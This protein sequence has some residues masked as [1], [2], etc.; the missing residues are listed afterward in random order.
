MSDR[1]AERPNHNM[2]TTNR[3]KY[4]ENFDN[5]QKN[6]EPPRETNIANKLAI[7]QLFIP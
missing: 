4:F 7:R 2:K 3:P 1:H 5:V 6:W